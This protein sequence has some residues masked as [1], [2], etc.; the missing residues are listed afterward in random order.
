M[1]FGFEDYNLLDDVNFQEQEDGWI[2][3]VNFESRLI[4]NIDILLYFVDVRSLSK[5]FLFVFGEN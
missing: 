1:N 3:D 5:V 4:G 2:E